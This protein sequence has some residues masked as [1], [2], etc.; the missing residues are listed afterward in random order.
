L[1]RALRRSTLRGPGARYRVARRDADLA[2]L[3]LPALTGL[4]LPAGVDAVP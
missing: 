3:T 1:K 2:V 4:V